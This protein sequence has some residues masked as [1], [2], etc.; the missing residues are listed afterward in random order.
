MG[1]KCIAKYIICRDDTLKIN[2]FDSSYSVNFGLARDY[3]TYHKIDRIQVFATNN[4]QAN[5]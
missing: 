3:C 5:L 4:V 2:P 1:K